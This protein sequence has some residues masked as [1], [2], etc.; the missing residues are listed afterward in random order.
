MPITWR[1][2][3]QVSGNER[4]VYTALLT[5]YQIGILQEESSSQ[6]RGGFISKLQ[7]SIEIKGPIRQIQKPVP[8]AILGWSLG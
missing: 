2:G 6:L 8:V 4:P 1:S 5:G 3:C 7:R